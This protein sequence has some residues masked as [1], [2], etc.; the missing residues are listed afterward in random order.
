MSEQVKI[1]SGDLG[2]VTQTVIDLAAGRMVGRS[3]DLDELLDQVDDNMEMA[4][5]AHNDG[6]M[7]IAAACAEQAACCA[8]LVAIAM[9]RMA[10][11][12]PPIQEM[13]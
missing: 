6:R 7:P 13:N 2:T 3:N 10:K 11:D 8:L 5:A 1:Q 12:M 4:V 9:R